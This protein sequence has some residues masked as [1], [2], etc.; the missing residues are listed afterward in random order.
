MNERVG[1]LMAGDSP[2]HFDS[3][4]EALREHLPLLD[5]LSETEQ[6]PQWHAEGDVAT[7]TRMVCEELE[8]ALEAG[9]LDGWRDGAARGRLRLATLLHD[10]AKPVTTRREERDGVERVLAPHHAERGASYIAHRLLDAGL[11]SAAI[12]EVMALVR[13][14]HDPKHMVL[15]DRPDGAFRELARQVDVRALHAL[16]LADMRGRRCADRAEQIE[17]IELFRLRCEESGVWD[18]AQARHTEQAFVSHVREALS[19]LP[20]LRIARGITQGLNDWNRG[21]IH[22]PHEAVARELARGERR[23]HVVLTCGPSGSGKSAAALTRYADYVWISLDE[24]REELTGSAE[25][26]RANDRVV[27]LARERLRE[28]LRA[29]RDVVWDATSLVRDFR[30]PVLGLARDYQALTTILAMHVAPTMCQARN[31]ER[32]R[33]VPQKVLARQFDFASWPTPGEAHQLLVLDAAGE[34][35]QDTLAG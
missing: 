33:R 8:E 28:A 21:E 35:V 32:E 9:A 3:D 2:L 24:V 25:D 7:H 27:A 34:V 29:Q 20:E 19:H 16:E 12:L 10:V 1:A 13:L 4:H 31:R 5:R 26:Q 22:T 18:A 6:D 11:D 30:S 15:R 14:H 23:C 17:H